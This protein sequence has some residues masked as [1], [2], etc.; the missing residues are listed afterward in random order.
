[1]RTFGDRDKRS[2]LA[3]DEHSDFRPTFSM[4]NHWTEDCQIVATQKIY[5]CDLNFLR[6]KKKN[7]Y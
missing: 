1:M 3:V 6:N 2:E 5:R 4:Q 7:Y